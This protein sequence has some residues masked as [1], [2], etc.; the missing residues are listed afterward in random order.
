VVWNFDAPTNTEIHTAQPI[1]TNSVMFI[2]N[3][4]PA[5]LIV[6]NKTTGAIEHQ[7]ELPVKFPDS[8]HRQF[9]RARLTAAGTI[10]VAH[11]DLGKIVEYDWN[12]NALWSRT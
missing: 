6:M 12:G 5:K 9:R 10:L 2:E 7:F 8:V 1:G 11:L 3:G 4:N